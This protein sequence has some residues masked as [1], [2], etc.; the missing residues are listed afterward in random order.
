[1]A[2]VKSTL[3][4]PHI[5]P[6]V[7]AR[8]E[9]PEHAARLTQAMREVAAGCAEAI[10]EWRAWHHERGSAAL[11]RQGQACGPCF[12]PALSRRMYARATAA[13]PSVSGLTT[14][15]VLK[16]LKTTITAKDSS[17]FQCKMWRA[18]LAGWENDSCF[19]SLPLRIY[20]QSAK[21]VNAPRAEGQRYQHVEI[22]CKVLRSP[23]GGLDETRLRIEHPRAGASEDYKKWFAMLVEMVRG[24]RKFSESQI[25]WSRGKWGLRL[26]VAKE[27]PAVALDPKRLLF[28]R[29]GM[30]CAWYT[31]FRGRSASWGTEKL[32]AVRA[33]REKH[34]D[35]RM[36][37]YR[38]RHWQRF[39]RTF[40]QQTVA[41]LRELVLKHRV[42]KVVVFDGRPRCALATVGAEDKREPT[43]FPVAQFRE[44]LKKTLQLYGCEVVGRANFKSVKRRKARSG[45]NFGA[46]VVR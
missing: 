9:P 41:E 37:G 33:A 19:T 31:R 39:C 32:A 34:I 21:L 22:V 18:M 16:W 30:K 15:T 7:I 11:I 3:A 20:S 36:S 1:M 40:N 25:V 26:T 27:V 12:P 23:A 5:V 17:K 8:I 2:H 35:L 45:I 43:N 29:C 13:T 24:Q 44:F 4:N 14:A 6:L 42:G 10:M 38:T 28:V 46:S